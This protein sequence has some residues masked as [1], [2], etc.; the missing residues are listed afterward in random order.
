MKKSISVILAVLMLCCSLS[1]GVFAAEDSITVSFSAFDGEVL[2]KKQNL[3]VTAQTAESFGLED[4]DVDHNGEAIEGATALDVLV[5]AHKACYG[6]AFTAETASKYLVV[7]SGQIKLAFG[8]NANASG[9]AVNNEAPHDDNYNELWGCYT[10]YS[11][12]ETRIENGDSMS[13]FF[14]QDTRF[15]SDLYAWFTQDGET[16]TSMKTLV[17]TPVT[18]TLEGFCYGWYSC[19]KDEDKGIAPLAGVDVYLVDANGNFTLLGQTDENG[20]ISVTAPDKK[21]TYSLCAYGETMDSYGME[22]PVIA[23]WCDWTVQTQAQANWDKIVNFL[24]S[25][26]EM[27]RTILHIG[28]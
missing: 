3:T 23:S 22:T 8:K 13:Y 14:Y 15:Y 11:V 1:V 5:A 9:F 7:S 28:K 27:L 16:V 18:L 26:I 20:Q 21:G 12:T 24:R 6:D 10:G 4:D 25:I 2:M 19:S 17:K